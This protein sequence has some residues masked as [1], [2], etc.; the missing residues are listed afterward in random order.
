MWLPDQ[1]SLPILRCRRKLRNTYLRIDKYALVDIF[2]DKYVP[3]DIFVDKY[4]LSY[5]FVDTYILLI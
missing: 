5:I 4:V 2:V 3:V 1:P